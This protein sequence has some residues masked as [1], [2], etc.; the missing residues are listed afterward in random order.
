MPR[1]KRCPPDDAEPLERRREARIPGSFRSYSARRH[2]DPLVR[3]SGRVVAQLPCQGF[4]LSGCQRQEMPFGHRH[5]RRA[6]GAIVAPRSGRDGQDEDAH[7]RE[8]GNGERRFHDSRP[9][10]PSSASRL[11]MCGVLRRIG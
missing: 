2:L 11:F 8:R 4:C 10:P 6:V 1:K 3:G 5:N 9:I 7:S